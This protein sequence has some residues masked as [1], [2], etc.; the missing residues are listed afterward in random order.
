MEELVAELGSSVSLRADLDVTRGAGR[1]A[2]YVAS[3]LKVLK[4]DKRA[5]FTRCIPTRSAQQIFC[6]VAKTPRHL[7]FETRP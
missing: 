6:T 1:P 4:S 7:G 3:W 5:I 2:S